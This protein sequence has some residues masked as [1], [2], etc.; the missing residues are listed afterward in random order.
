MTITYTIPGVPL[1]DQL[2]EGTSDGQPDENARD[3][4]V[5]ASNAAMATA[6]LHKPFNGDQLK[7]MDNNYGQGYVGF[8]S[9]ANLV[10]TMARLGIK[11]ARVAHDTQQELIDELH[12]H[13]P[14]GHACIITMPSQWGTAPPNPRTYRGYSHVGLACGV[15]HDGPD[16]AIRVMNPWGGFWHDGSDSYWAARLLEGEIWVGEYVGGKTMGNQVPSGWKDDGKTLVAPNGVPVMRGFR[17]YALAWPGGWEANNWPLKPEQTITSGS[18]EPGNTSIGPG[19]RQDFRYRSLGWTAS[20]N[21]YVI[22]SG[23]DLLALESQLATM[24]AHVA[25]LEAQVKQLQDQQLPDP[26]AAEAM[27]ALMELAKALKLVE[28]AAA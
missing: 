22:Y 28:T 27:A 14:Q 19:S 10:D 7:D 21:V 26:K 5:F 6:Y 25:Q 15:G 20:R 18:I 2:H 23:Q 1:V 17:D 4:C 12:W 8:A 16:G 13:I 9:E 11:V 24:Q 3:N